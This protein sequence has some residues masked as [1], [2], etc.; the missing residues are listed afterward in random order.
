[1]RVARVAGA[2]GVVA[3]GAGVVETAAFLDLEGLDDGG[4]RVYLVVMRVWEYEISFGLARGV[5]LGNGG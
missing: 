5:A 3:V 1:V 2:S 4:V